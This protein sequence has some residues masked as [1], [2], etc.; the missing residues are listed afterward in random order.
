MCFCNNQ[1]DSHNGG[2]TRLLPPEIGEA[3][4]ILLAPQRD[5]GQEAGT[6]MFCWM[7]SGVNNR[8]GSFI[9]HGG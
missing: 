3:H 2:F 7:F 1:P 9:K 5:W 8:S 6:E 4:C